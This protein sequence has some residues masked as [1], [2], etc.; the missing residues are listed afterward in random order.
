MTAT[1]S[2]QRDSL[3]MLADKAASWK[4]AWDLTQA[5]LATAEA[6]GTTSAVRV[7]VG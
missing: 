4:A 7:S 1:P 6:A 2:P 3:G 5:T